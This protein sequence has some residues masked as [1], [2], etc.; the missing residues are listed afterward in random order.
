MPHS[1]RELLKFGLA[2]AATLVLPGATFIERADARS[3]DEDPHFFLMI[4][5]NGGADCSYMFDAR[6]LA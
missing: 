1:R 3:Q 5:L 2:G 4:V 6:P